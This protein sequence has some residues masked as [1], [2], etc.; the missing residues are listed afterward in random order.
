MG[1]I[2]KTDG[3]W[4][5]TASWRHGS[6]GFRGSDLKELHDVYLKPACWSMTLIMNTCMISTSLYFPSIEQL[7]S[8]HL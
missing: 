4:G 7:L 2:L 6:H 8:N 3:N 1:G 5:R